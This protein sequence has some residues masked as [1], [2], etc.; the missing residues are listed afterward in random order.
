M[1]LTLQRYMHDIA[2]PALLRLKG[3][4]DTPASRAI[5]DEYVSELMVRGQRR[6]EVA[7]RV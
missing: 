1:Q 6:A 2:V 5:L 4:E 3:L 7:R